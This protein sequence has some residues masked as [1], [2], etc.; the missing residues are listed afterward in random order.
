MT[1]DTFTDWRK[2]PYGH[3]NSDCVEVAAGQQ[4]V[5]VRDTK[6]RRR[7]HVLQFTS[8]AWRTFVVA[9]KRESA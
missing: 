4:V 2:A 3:G 1:S 5:G 8:A 7:G 6:H 9:T